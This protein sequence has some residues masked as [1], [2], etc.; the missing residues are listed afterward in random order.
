MGNRLFKL[1]EASGY[2][3]VAFSHTVHD[4]REIRKS[5]VECAKGYLKWMDHNKMT[6]TEDQKK[7]FNG[8][9]VCFVRIPLL[10]EPPC[11]FSGKPLNESSG[12]INHFLKR[13]TT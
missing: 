4:T 13:S 3:C 11:K 2:N 12:I 1:M 6:A 9:C 5:T 8:V 10:H 7:A